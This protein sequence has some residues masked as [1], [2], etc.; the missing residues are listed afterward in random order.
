MPHARAPLVCDDCHV[1]SHL[2]RRSDPDILYTDIIIYRFAASCRCCNGDLRCTAIWSAFQLVEIRSERISDA[3]VF[4]HRMQSPVY[5]VPPLPTA[6]QFG[7]DPEAAVAQWW[8]RF[9]PLRL[10]ICG[11]RVDGG[12][13]WCVLVSSAV[14]AEGK[15][16]SLAC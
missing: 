2:R 8:N 14:T 9:D 16:R 4:T 13:G 12:K 7:S 1:S 15:T 5:T 3:R 11:N 6:V 10:A